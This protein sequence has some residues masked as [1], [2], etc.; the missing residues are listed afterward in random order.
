[1]FNNVMNKYFFILLT[2]N[3]RPTHMRR[4]FW[5]IVFL[6][7]YSLSFSQ[8]YSSGADPAS[9]HWKQIKSPFFKIV[10][11]SEFEQEARRFTAILDSLYLYG[12]HSLEH[13]PKPIRVLM[14]SRDAYS[15]GFVSWAPKRMEVYT[16]PHQDMFAQ[17][18]LEQ[19]AIHEFRHVVQIDK[20]N[21]GLTRGLGYLFGQ[22]AVGAVLGLYAPLW[23]LEGDAVVTETLLSPSGRGRKPE[24]EQE[25]R[26]QL[27]EKGSYS[28]DKAF[29]G[30]YQN[31]V[32]NHY[33]MG[34]LLV[35]GARH[36]Y[37]A[38][39][40]QRALK[41]TARR[42]WSITP[43]NKGIKDVTGM[44]K[45]P[46]YNSVFDQWQEE[47]KQ[48]ELELSLTSYKEITERDARYK[49]Y[50][51]PVAI[52]DHTLL[53]EVTGP[54]EVQR[55]VSIDRLT[56]KASTLHIPGM[57]EKEPFS[58][59]AGKLV[60]A[61]LEPHPRWENQHFSVLRVMNITTGQ[62]K[63]ITSR[64]RYFAPALSPDGQTIATVQVSMSNAYS[65]HLLDALT[66][67]IIKTIDTPDH[68][69]PMT[70]SWH[71]NGRD[72][73]LILLGDQGKQISILNTESAQWQ[74]VTQPDFT[75]IRMP[76]FMGDEII[77]SGSW[78]GIEN[79]YRI[80]PD[81][82]QLQQL[83]SSRFGAAMATASPS[84]NEI[85][86]ADY[87]SDGYQ[88]VM[89]PLAAIQPKEFK[90]QSLPIETKLTK[91]QEDEKGIPDFKGLTGEE[92]AVEEYSKWN[93]FN[94]HSW[95]PAFVNLDESTVYPGLSALSQ[96]LLNTTFVNVG[97]HF[98][99]QNRRE[100]YY[101]KIEYKG[102]WPVLDLEMKYGD[103]IAQASGYFINE[104][105][106]IHVDYS[107]KQYYTTLEG[108][109]KVPINLSRGRYFRQIEPGLRAAFQNISGYSYQQTFVTVQNDQLIKKETI[110]QNVKS[111]DIT[112]LEY[113]L[114]A[115]NI[116]RTTLR[117]VAPRWGQVAEFNY[118][119]TPVGSYNYGSAIGIHTRLYFPGLSRHH[120]IR[121]DNDYHRKDRG[122]QFRSDDVYNYYLSLSDF[123]KFPRGVNG[124]TNDE[125]YSF[126]GDYMLPLLNPD[127]NIPGVLYLKRITMN[128]F[129]D[130]SRAVINRQSST[131]N[132]WNKYDYTFQS[133]GSE[134][135]TELH[136]FR[137]VFPIGLGYRYAWLPES[138]DH[139]QEFILSLNF[140][141]FTVN[142]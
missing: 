111:F 61:E 123:V 126:K 16:T 132:E 97:Y 50:L 114:F 90:P 15:N 117:D 134:V 104:T 136:P 30:S 66:G 77:F 14:H 89:T 8:Y 80:R 48:Q 116:K 59:N 45:V 10:F 133:I 49:N 88:L 127:L 99:S 7:S 55:F 118:R 79:L 112:S 44:N 74:T 71:Q 65:I 75:Q 119:H 106:T 33:H 53:A 47:W 18:W 34:Y 98:D 28:Y 23:F 19:L 130:Y 101:A 141:G 72:L 1:M 140:S 37:G 9:I 22:Q 4:F 129:Y 24:F 107:E 67:D 87:N 5:L 82:S 69:F 54:G 29:F 135:H 92:Y 102:W 122:D 95:A 51:W 60:W 91:M 20:L 12:G 105:D 128:L 125:L 131:S 35:A 2:T 13:T 31:Y 137:F 36:Q 40:W 26:A 120:T 70:P 108:G 3:T 78:T 17:D 103:D 142:Q 81:G 38:D 21:Q 73:V 25:L 84:N 63:K 58:Y 46:L 57:R 100:R 109:F 93:L 11:P 62:Q 85:F 64:S 83:T 32:P 138:K 39:V 6:F 76:R 56:G 113:R 41:V 110:T 115:Y 68:L 52:D 27:L 94:F 124:I 43:F 42:P 121:L 96:N 139:F 86:Y